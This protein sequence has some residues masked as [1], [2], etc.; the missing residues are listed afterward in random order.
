MK[1][2]HKITL[3]ISG[4]AFVAAVAFSSIIFWEILEEPVRLIDNE[5]SHMAISLL[6]QANKNSQSPWTFDD[7]RLPYPAERYWI[8]IFDEDGR[9]LYSSSLT[10]YTDIPPVKNKSRYYTEKNIKREQINLQQDKYDEILFRVRVFTRQV[11]SHQVTI[12]IARPIE[13]LEQ[14]LQELVREIL[15]W[16]AISTLLIVAASYTMAGKILS[17]VVTMNRLAREITDKSLD[18]RLPVGKNHDELDTLA[19]SLNTMFDRLR[20][21]FD[22]QRE[23]IGNASHELKSPLT[24][25]VLSQEEL[26]LNSELPLDM[27]QDLERQLDTMRRMSKLIR[28]L[29]DLSRLEQQETITLEPLNPGAIIEQVLDDYQDMLTATGITV[30][31]DLAQDISLPGDVDKILRLC[32]NLIDNAIRYNDAKNGQLTILLTKEKQHIRLEVANTG[33]IIP[34]QDVERVFE[35]FYRVEKSRSIAHGGSGLGLT[36]SKRIVEMH[37]GTIK[38]S[39]EKE[40]WTRITVILPLG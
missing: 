2:R 37:R 19:T 18:K 21:S 26:L 40:G 7:S 5:L 9:V 10:R 3:W 11:G 12:R 28:N 31:T 14:E 13:E 32:I 30:T 38:I 24:L 35:Q 17:P 8:K 29:L 25:L 33:K 34:P 16:L 39:S 4:V 15:A 1:I 22:R 23:F 6:E 20:H 36:I 27:R